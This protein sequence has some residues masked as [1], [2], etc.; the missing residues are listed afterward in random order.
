MFGS[1]GPIASGVEAVTRIGA[2]RAATL[3]VPE[4][5]GTKTIDVTTIAISRTTN[6]RNALPRMAGEGE[7][8]NNHFANRRRGR[9][10][11][12]CHPA[13]QIKYDVSAE[14]DVRFYRA[15]RLSLVH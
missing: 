3:N 7:S 11:G 10:D 15:V 13:A 14:N 2:G 4:V 6:G 5:G 1:N 8:D 12:D 9:F